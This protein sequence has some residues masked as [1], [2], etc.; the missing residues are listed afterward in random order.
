MHL[1]RERI[2]E[3]YVNMEFEETLLC[4]RY[5]PTLDPKTALASITLLATNVGHEHAGNLDE[6]DRVFR[7]FVRDKRKLKDEVDDIKKQVKPIKEKTVKISRPFITRK[8]TRC[9][10]FEY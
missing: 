5:P 1:S 10:K 7:Q 4:M 2:F 9:R 8:V 6:I 3:Y